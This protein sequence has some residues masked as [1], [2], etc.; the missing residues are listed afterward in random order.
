MGRVVLMRDGNHKGT[1]V[2]RVEG[3]FRFVSLDWGTAST[4]ERCILLVLGKLP[5]D[6]LSE[7]FACDLESPKGLALVG[8]DTDDDLLRFVTADEV[9]WDSHAQP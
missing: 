1:E 4:A 6:D 7:P 3:G 8:V 9:L 2:Y 5:A